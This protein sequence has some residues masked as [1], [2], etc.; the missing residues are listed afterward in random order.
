MRAVPLLTRSESGSEFAEPRRTEVRSERC[1]DREFEDDG[2]GN[3]DAA[4]E[5]AEFSTFESLEG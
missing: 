1:S 3:A 2:C 4:D 5:A